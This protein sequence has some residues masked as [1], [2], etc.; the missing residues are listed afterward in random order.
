VAIFVGISEMKSSPDGTIKTFVTFTTSGDELIPSEITDILRLVPNEAHG[1]GEPYIMGPRAG[2]RTARTG[3]WYFT[4]DKVVASQNI[5]DHL[6]FLIVALSPDHTRLVLKLNRLEGVIKKRNLKAVVGLFWHGIP[7]AKPPS[8][9]RQFVAIFRSAL[10]DV[11]K[12]FD[13]DES[14]EVA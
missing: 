1:K 3:I 7:G 12:D 11:E 14:S 9:P 10:I 2:T 4:T 8:I 6:A 13:T 5:L